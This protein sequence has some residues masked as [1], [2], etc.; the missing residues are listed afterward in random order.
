M[1]EDDN[2]IYHTGHFFERYNE[3]RK[4]E[5]KTL[6]EIIHTYLDDSGLHHFEKLE[7]IAP[8]IFTIFCISRSGVIMGTYNKE[9]KLLKANTYL[10][11]EMLSKNQSEIKTEII[12]TLKKYGDTSADLF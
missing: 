7:E 1:T 6:T 5:L 2:L 9:L 12:N 11:N 4:L 3:R 8:G 10:P